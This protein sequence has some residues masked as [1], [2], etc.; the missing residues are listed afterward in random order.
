MGP[1]P[2]GRGAVHHLSPASHHALRAP[3][4]QAW[5]PRCRG[6]LLGRPVGR[7]AGVLHVHSLWWRR[8]RSE[9]QG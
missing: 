2:V 1:R 7:P 5:R 6:Q 8:R 3:G 9:E 4:R